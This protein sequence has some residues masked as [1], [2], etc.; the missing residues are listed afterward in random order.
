MSFLSS[1]SSFFSCP[2]PFIIRFSFSFSSSC[3]L[4]RHREYVFLLQHSFHTSFSFSNRIIRTEWLNRT[5][6]AFLPFPFSIHTHIVVF[7]LPSFLPV[8]FF[9]HN[10]CFPNSHNVSS[11]LFFCLALPSNTHW[12]DQLAFSF[13]CHFSRFT[14]CFLF[15]FLPV[16][17][18]SFLP[19]SSPS[20]ITHIVSLLPFHIG[21][22]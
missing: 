11:F 10:N 3:F 17:V 15:L 16:F 13:N 21:E 4:F 2:F 1:F 12:R 18:F 20:P 8:I 22:V 6:T 7:F 5:G 19:S 9:I 14:V